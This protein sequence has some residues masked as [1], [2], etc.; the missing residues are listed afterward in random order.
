VGM[1]GSLFVFTS[2]L[3]IS[4]AH[5]SIPL[6]PYVFSIPL[7]SFI[8]TLA[9]AFDTIGHRTI[10]KAALEKGENL[11]HHITI[12]CGIMSVALMCIG[13][14][15]KDWVYIPAL[16][17][18]ALSMFYSVIDELLHWR[19]YSEGQSDR[20]EM[21]SHAFIFIGHLIMVGA[22]W[23]WFEAGYPGLK[24]TFQA[25]NQTI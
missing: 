22:W 7:G 5:F 17:F 12:F 18:T 13:F 16:V 1:I 11:V 9:I 20:V 19:R 10:Y 15:Y 3:V 6:E 21:W 8:F 4:A 23:T 25:I 24:E 14:T 2:A